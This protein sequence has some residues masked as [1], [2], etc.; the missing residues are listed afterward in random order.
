MKL[1]VGI[2]DYDWFRFHSA[3]EK[4][5]EVNFWSPSSNVPFR[6]LSLGGPFLFKLKSARN[7]I[8]G[9]GFFVR[10]EPLS[11]S[12]AWETFGEANGAQSLVEFRFLISRNRHEQILP[13]EDPTVGCTIL[14]EPFF[15]EESDWIPFRLA[16]GIQR[17]RTVDMA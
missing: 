7:Y 15:F 5:E 13:S 4:V 11:I 3:K 14:T 16:S 1:W 17:G 12:R 6:A 10:Y 2:T 8:A 9:G